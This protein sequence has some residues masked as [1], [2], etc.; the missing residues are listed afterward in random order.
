M[1]I[2]FSKRIT[3]GYGSLPGG[4]ITYPALAMVKSAKRVDGRSDLWDIIVEPWVADFEV[5]LA[6]VEGNSCRWG[7]PCASGGETMAKT[8]SLVVMNE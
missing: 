2:Q 3:T 5:V 7:A 4:F 1:R 8:W 6:L